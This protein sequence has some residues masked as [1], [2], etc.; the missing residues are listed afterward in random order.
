VVFLI[1]T[2]EQNSSILTLKQYIMCFFE[3]FNSLYCRCQG[4]DPG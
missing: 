3:K 2:V 1:K 4:S